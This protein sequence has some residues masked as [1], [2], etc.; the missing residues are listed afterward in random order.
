MHNFNFELVFR[1]HMYEFLTTENLLPMNDTMVL[2]EKNQT[3]SFDNVH[4][5][6]L[7]MQETI[8]SIARLQTIQTVELYEA[9]MNISRLQNSPGKIDNVNAS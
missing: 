8:T 6:I 2:C 9:K 3:L 5:T 1:Y 4:E 7:K